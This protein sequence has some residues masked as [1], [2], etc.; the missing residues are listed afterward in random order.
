MES[1]L[2]AR[3]DFFA[4]ISSS[5]CAEHEVLL[6]DRVP[7]STTHLVEVLRTCFEQHIKLLLPAQHRRV[8]SLISAAYDILVVPLRMVVRSA[9]MQTEA[10]TLPLPFSL[11]PAPSGDLRVLN[12]ATVR[13][14]IQQQDSVCGL[15]RPSSQAF[16]EDRAIWLGLYNTSKSNDSTPMEHAQIQPESE[17]ESGGLLQV[18][19]GVSASGHVWVHRASDFLD[20]KKVA[21]V[22]T[23]TFLLAA[24]DPALPLVCVLSAGDEVTAQAL[25]SAHC[26]FK[27]FAVQR[28]DTM[29][30]RGVVGHE[31]S[32]DGDGEGV[33]GNDWFECVVF[34]GDVTPPLRKEVE[35]PAAPSHIFLLAGQSNMSGRGRQADLA[36]HCSLALAGKRGE[37][38]ASPFV[39]RPPAPR[40]VA[41]PSVHLSTH[42]SPRIK[43]FDAKEV[44]WS[45]L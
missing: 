13:F 43:A 44:V 32:L 3:I 1:F 26:G 25:L 42:Y 39:L 12:A 30:E 41:T 34:R 11:S 9:Q 5:F 22:L 16:V 20:W 2:S 18:A 28:H 38:R 24:V 10:Q 36:R 8:V 27:P 6:M 14:V 19:V 37:D 17:S 35:L 33:G 4:R 15:L 29:T 7:S 23:A 31:G 21:A 45:N 40:S